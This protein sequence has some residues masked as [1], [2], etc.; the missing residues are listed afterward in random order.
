MLKRP[1]GLYASASPWREI[2]R[3]QRE[4]N[5]LFDETALGGRTRVAPSY[6]AINVWTNEDGAVITAEL[7]GVNPEDIEISVVG[8]TLKLTGS[9]QPEDLPEGARYHRRERGH[10]KFTRTFQLP[11]MVES[12]KV[13]AVFEKG[14]LHISAPRAEA[15][16]PRKITVKTA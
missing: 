13:E 14:V 6:P 5:R 10:G 15:E 7:P 8:E 16:K 9:R 4:M 11:F 3:M 2:E 1:F 12:D